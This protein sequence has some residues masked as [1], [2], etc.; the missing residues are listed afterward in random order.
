MKTINQL[1]LALFV[2]LAV[3]CSKDDDNDSEQSVLPVTMEFVTDL[4]FPE[5]SEGQEIQISFNRPAPVNGTITIGLD[6]ADAGGFTTTPAMVDGEIQLQIAKGAT[7]ASFTF[8]TENDDEL[9]GNREFSF[10]L[11]D[12]SEHFL[13]GEK[14]SMEITIFEDEV[15]AAV[16][17]AWLNYQILENQTEGLEVPVQ[18]SV[19]APG[20]AVVKIRV[21]GEAVG[22]FLTTVP[23]MDANNIIHLNVASGVWDVKIGLQPKNNTTLDQ[24]RNLKF[25]IVE[26]SGALNMGDRLELDLLLR[27]DE[28]AGKL[29]SVESI[30]VNN[31]LLKT[32]E[33]SADGRI[34]K[35]SLT[36]S[37][38]Y[39]FFENYHYNESGQLTGT[40]G[41]AGD[42]TALTWEDGKIVK[43]EKVVGFFGVNQ[44]I[45]EY[46]DGK[47][48]R[49]RDFTLDMNRNATETDRYHYT[50]YSSGNLK[51][52]SRYSLVNG[53]W[54][55][56]TM[57]TYDAY[58]EQPN[59]SPLEAAPGLPLQQQ[60][61]ATQ[62]TIEN[63]ETKMLYYAHVFDADGKVT[64][65][66]DGYETLKYSYY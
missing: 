22:D 10:L 3:S 19:P 41:I 51:T 23:P 39:T 12:A 66:F 16:N 38:G 36:N 43:S 11:L 50:Y 7:G 5:L 58:S 63:N 26:V 18:F 61:N 60:L 42:F 59:P 1:M 13:I 46:E 57:R 45:F 6:P 32:I 47:L 21:E 53:S 24:H 52:E 49:K 34:S 62:I 44:S 14:S 29:K 27:D 4:S 65:R 56:I 40:S 20:A 28:L 8:D 2:A 30:S 15:P 64:E 31:R 55:E 54:K 9:H 17:F 25:S 35:V 37:T 48:S 33:Y